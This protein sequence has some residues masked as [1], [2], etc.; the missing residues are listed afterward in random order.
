MNIDR[1]PI[2]K[3]LIE[4]KDEG[5]VPFH[6]PGHKRGSIHKKT[7]LDF[8]FENILA[9]DTTEVP[10]VD[11]LHCPE[12]AIFEA[13]RLAA[14]AFGA[15]HSFFLV[16]GTTSG[17]YSMIMAS[18]NPGDKIVIPRNC[19]SSVYGAVILGRLVP[20]YIEPEIDNELGMAMGIKTGALENIL[21]KHKDAKAV[22][23]TYP[24][25]Y[26]VC[27]D[28]KK[29]A[30]T[31]HKKG[32]LLLVDEAH[33]SHFCFNERLP[34]SAIEAGAD[35]TSQSIH[36]TLPAMTQSSMLH[37][38]SKKV[39]IEKLKIFLQLTQTTSPSHI[40]LASLDT[41]RFIMQQFG[42]ELLDDVID[43]S[44]WA[45]NEI[46]KISGLYC[47]GSD[48]IGKYGIS[49]F[50]PTRITV[51]FGA[52][53]ISGTKVGDILRKDFK[54]QVEM[55]DLYNIVAITTIGD[56]RADYERLTDAL[57]SIEA[58]RG[59]NTQTIPSTAFFRTPEPS[60]MP[61]EALYYEKEQVD[62]GQSIGRTCGEMIIPYPPGIPVL[63]PG[64]PITGEIYEYL[65]LCAECGIKINGASD[66]KLRT[67]RVIK[68]RH[69]S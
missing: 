6:M 54:I 45:R 42:R 43:W 38:K 22:V 34:L 11:N 29:I 68:D 9:L 8:L 63:M 44:G 53:G 62:M 66:S 51:N 69:G 40:L 5:A 28:L 48:R 17:I 14:E 60:L 32:M 56:D 46:N 13:Q 50:D 23:I 10:G 12:G 15:D 31:V 67:V 3:S 2:L 59:G 27:S 18:A 37:V 24:T 61:W 47:L 1:I 39:D 64:E 16:N 33:G 49:D 30:E 21:E 41:A 26:G 57:K 19:H 4:Y 36:K 20:V 58:I 35:M 65:K 55:A 52:L 7:G 25:Y